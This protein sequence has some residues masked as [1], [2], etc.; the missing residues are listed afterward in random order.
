MIYYRRVVDGKRI[1]LSAQTND[2][3]QAV[4]WRDVFEEKTGVGTGVPFVDSQSSGE[5]SFMTHPLQTTASAS[6]EFR[7][8][9]RT[10][11]LP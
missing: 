3:E 5:S 6:V 1:R 7:L 10:S 4:A 9:S 8:L 2:W 11:A